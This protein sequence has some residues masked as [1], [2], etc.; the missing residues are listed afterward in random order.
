MLA[1]VKFWVVSALVKQW[2]A[3]LTRNL[4]PA[5]YTLQIGIYYRKVETFLK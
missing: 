2:P 4:Q 1:L 5:V 3:T